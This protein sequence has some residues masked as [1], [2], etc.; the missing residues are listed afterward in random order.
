MDESYR[1]FLMKTILFLE[2]T[3]G[4]LFA[5]ILNLAS[6]SDFPMLRENFEN[7]EI[8]NF[9]IMMFEDSKDQN[10][11]KLIQLYKL[12]EEQR[13]TIIEKNKISEKDLDYYFSL[14]DID[15]KSFDDDDET[16]LFGD[17]PLFLN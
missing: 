10:V 5:Q 6:H 11:L 12:I 13:L 2:E 15:M 3:S 7:G 17:L 9:N 8:F 1:D 16:D 4:N 14:S